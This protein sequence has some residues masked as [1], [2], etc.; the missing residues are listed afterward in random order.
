MRY[1]NL[2]KASR[3]HIWTTFVG[4]TTGLTSSQLDKLA[5]VELNGRQIKNVL[6]TAQMLARHK[7]NGNVKVGIQEI[8]TILAIERGK[9]FS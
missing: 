2:T 6:K 8:E 4:Q 1:P 7:Q 3:R 9:D 5:E